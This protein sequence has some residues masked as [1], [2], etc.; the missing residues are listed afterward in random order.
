MPQGEDVPVRLFRAVSKAELDDVA[1][2]GGFRQKPDGS[3]YEGKLFATRIED[4]AAF[5]RINYR[6]D[7]AIG[8]DYPFYVLETRVPGALA[9]QF[10]VHTL[11]GWDASRLCARRSLTSPQSAQHHLR[12]NGYSI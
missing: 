4:K 12:D 6:L 1:S 2:F 5:G 7:S 10:E 9:A 3:S 11:D 8:L